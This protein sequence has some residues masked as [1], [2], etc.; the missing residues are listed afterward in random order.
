M[1]TIIP[2]H[3]RPIPLATQVMGNILD[4]SYRAQRDG[5]PHIDDSLEPQQAKQRANCLL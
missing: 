1:I 2:I 3:A 5:L 4:G